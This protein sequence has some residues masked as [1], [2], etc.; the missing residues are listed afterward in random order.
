MG[1]I[2]KQ[3]IKG[4][5]YSYIGVGIGFITT[6]ILFPR[7]LSSEEIGLLKLL[8]SFSILFAQ[9]GSLGFSNVINRLFPYFRDKDNGHNGFLLVALMVSFIGFILSLFSL[10]ILKP[11]II[12]NNIQDSALF[13]QYFNYLIPLIFFTLYFGLFDNYIKAL[14]DAV[15]GTVLKEFIQRLLILLA[16]VFYFTGLVNFKTL[17]LLYVLALSLPTLFIFIILIVNGKFVLNK[18]GNIFTPSLWREIS[19]LCFHG[20]LTGFG[21]I[22]VLQLD[23][24]MV[25]HYLGLSLTGIYATTFFFATIIL[26]PSRPL[27]KITTTIIADA[28]KNNDLSTINLIYKKSVNTQT[29]IAVLLF[30]GLW[31][32]IENIFLI[33]PGEYEA[34]K[35]VIFFIGLKNIIEM[36]TGISSTILQTSKYYRVNTLI[37]SVFLVLMF[38]SLLILIPFAGINGTAIGILISYS[39]TASVRYVFLKVKYNF[40]PFD[41]KVLLI[42][43]VGI[44][45]F[46]AGYFVPRSDNFILDICFRSCIT[47]GTY[48]F[49]S[50]LLKTSENVNQFIN[51]ILKDIYRKVN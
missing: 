7:I 47:G 6:A 18:P 1:I 13:V 46:L 4:T 42:F 49:L 43:F 27:L 50:I 39:L 9:F 37:I 16:V 31:V 38:V 8:V 12:R 45:S 33:I 20:I 36:A 11:L 48:L 21:G 28:W 3:A 22:A 2:Q 30:I 35:W 41:Y 40:E 51:Q 15:L 44:V 10:F 34:G 26:I 5:I 17:V 24:I 14:Y 19:V 32:N 25:N 29:W 23:S